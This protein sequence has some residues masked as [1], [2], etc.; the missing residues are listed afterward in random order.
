MSV[1]DKLTMRVRMN[2]KLVNEETDSLEKPLEPDIDF[3]VQNHFDDYSQ[4][5]QEEEQAQGR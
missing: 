2:G 4:G 1:G 5:G 3:F